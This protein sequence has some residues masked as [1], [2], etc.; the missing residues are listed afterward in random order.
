MNT[1]IRKLLDQA[2]QDVYKELKS[3][4]RRSP[5][6]LQERIN[7][8]FAQLIIKHCAETA[9]GKFGL[10]PHITHGEKMRDYFGV[11]ND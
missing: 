8:R 6:S 1:N 2:E 4:S 9:D 5:I 11:K 7:D 10:Y 3:S